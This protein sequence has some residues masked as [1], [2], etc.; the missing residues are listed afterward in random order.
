MTPET[1][2]RIDDLFDE[3]LQ[4]DPAERGQWLERACPDED[5]RAEIGRLLE[6]DNRAT[7]NGFL[8]PPDWTRRSLDP[9]TTFPPREDRDSAGASPSIGPIEPLPG[10]FTCGFTP[11]AAIA[12]GDA[13]R[14]SAESESV[15]QM[16]LREL[17]VIYI[18]IFTMAIVWR[19]LVVGRIYPAV[20]AVNTLAIVILACVALLLSGRRH[21]SVALLQALE[22]GIIGTTAGILSFG[23]YRLILE[24]SLRDD[25]MMAQLVMK[26]N[27]LITAV[28]ILTYGLY[29]PKS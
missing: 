26:N 20:F 21:F 27:V 12:A 6:H 7:R 16:R 22:L 15:V 23:Q 3:A 29:V 11:R 2:Q 17:A 18:F 24:E 19:H 4:L 10:E 1:W 28:L 8:T 5:L 9:T 25:T 14:P 13:P